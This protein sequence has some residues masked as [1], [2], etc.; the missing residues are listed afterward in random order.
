MKPTR[1]SLAPATNKVERLKKY[2]KSS[3]PLERLAFACLT[4][5]GTCVLILDILE[6]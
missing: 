3:T 5:Y 4:F 1:A 2:I 6:R